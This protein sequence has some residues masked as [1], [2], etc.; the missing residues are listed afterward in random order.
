MYTG[1]PRVTPNLQAGYHL[2]GQLR[3]LQLAYQQTPRAFHWAD[4]IGRPDLIVYLPPLNEVFKFQKTNITPAQLS[5]GAF[6]ETVHSWLFYC[7]C[8]CICFSCLLLPFCSIDGCKLTLRS[9]TLARG[10]QRTQ[11]HREQT[12]I[13]SLCS[14]LLPVSYVVTTTIVLD[15]LKQT[16]H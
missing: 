9:L 4:Q 8:I 6:L 3:F 12:R 2:L 10:T 1:T 11:E 14:M 16:K 5:F 7:T 13:G 15:A